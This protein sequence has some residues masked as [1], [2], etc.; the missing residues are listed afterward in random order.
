MYFAGEK[1]VWVHVEPQ[2]EREKEICSGREEKK[3]RIKA[4]VERNTVLEGAREE[5]R[6]EAGNGEFILAAMMVA[7][8]ESA[9]SEQLPS[10]CTESIYFLARRST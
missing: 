9:I 4:K 5:T 3:K 1:R 2:K 6:R 10:S 7:V 8:S